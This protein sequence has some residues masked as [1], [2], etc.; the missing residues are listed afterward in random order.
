[1]ISISCVKSKRGYEEFTFKGHADF[2]VV[3]RD[4]VCSA[5]SVLFINTFN[6]IEKFTND[7]PSTLQEK[8]FIKVTFP[9]S[10]SDKSKLLLDSMMLGL[11]EISK[12][13]RE[14]ISLTVKEV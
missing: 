4:I 8:D 9:D 10:L 1:M 12:N 3:G 11:V 14:N 7:K 2:D 5:V 13:Y 6:S